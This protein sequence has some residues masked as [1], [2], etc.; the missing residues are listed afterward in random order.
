VRWASLS[1][2]LNGQ[3]TRQR[4]LDD[5]GDVGV[6]EPSQRVGVSRRCPGD[7]NRHLS[8]GVDD[9]V[10]RIMAY[11]DGHRWLWICVGF[12]SGGRLGIIP[13]T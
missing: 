13:P 12:R 6:L 7:W 10:S 3:M 1:R 8:T 5:G 4:G 9:L 11:V 2:W